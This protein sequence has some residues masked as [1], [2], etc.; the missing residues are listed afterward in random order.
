M[1]RP[2]TRC[3]G[4]RRDQRPAQ[5]MARSLLTTPPGGDHLR[6]PGDRTLRRRAHRWVLAAAAHH[7]RLTS[8]VKPSDP[9]PRSGP[10]RK[11]SGR[12]GQTSSS[13]RCPYDVRL[14]GS[15]SKGGRPAELCCR[16]LRHGC[17]TSRRGASPPR[18]CSMQVS[19]KGIHL[20][21]DPGTPP[22]APGRPRARDRRGPGVDLAGALTVPG[23]PRGISTSSTP[24]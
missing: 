1:R 3:R 4:R 11:S 21:G 17:S 8:S 23:T 10:G 24:P 22:S 15:C 16:Q 12:G 19:A 18:C 9:R 20:V 7:A 2:D 5:L 14:L 13:R 6:H